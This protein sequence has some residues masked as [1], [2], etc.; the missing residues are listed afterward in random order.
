[1]KKFLKKSVS[2]LDGIKK[3]DNNRRIVGFSIQCAV[4]WNASME[5]SRQLLEIICGPV[6]CVL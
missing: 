3:L 1:M 2:A 4:T 6:C 5:K